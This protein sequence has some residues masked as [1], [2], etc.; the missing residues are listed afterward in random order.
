[1]KKNYIIPMAAKMPEGNVPRL[2]A[3][4]WQPDHTGAKQGYIETE[5]EDMWESTKENHYDPWE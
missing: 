4:S 2:L 5:D 1:M 3:G